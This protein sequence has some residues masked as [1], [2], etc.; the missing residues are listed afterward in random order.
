MPQIAVNLQNPITEQMTMGVGT[1]NTVT[2]L[3]MVY[4][5]LF[6]VFSFNALSLIPLGQLASHLM[7]R[8]TRLPAYGWNLL[9]SIAAVFVFWGLSFLWSPPVV[10]FAVGFAFLALFLRGML[11][12]TAIVAALA[13]GVVGTSFQVAAYDLYSPYQILTL[14]PSGFT[15]GSSPTAIMVNHYFF[16]DMY[17]LGPDGAAMAGVRD[18]VRTYYGLPYDFQKSPE[19]VLVVGGLGK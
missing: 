9:G 19:D 7:G 10:W 8:S 5:F 12:T 1:A 4:G 17:N 3:V 15:P 14:Y 13:L 11:T 16:Q 6:W 18:L 2:R